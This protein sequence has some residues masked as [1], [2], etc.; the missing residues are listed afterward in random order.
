MLYK[1]CPCCGANLD[2]D[3]TCDCLCETE[4]VICE[5]S[6]LAQKFQGTPLKGGGIE[7]ESDFY[8]KT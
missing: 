2:P 1:T 6:P 8:S 5:V 7:D 4:K 3:E